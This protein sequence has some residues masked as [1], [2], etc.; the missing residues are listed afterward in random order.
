M[1]NRWRWFRFFLWL[2]VVGF[3]LWV[4]GTLFHM[5][6]IV[7]LW[8]ANPPES[9][10]DFFQGTNFTRTVLNFFGPPWMLARN[11]PLL[12]ALVLGWQFRTH[13]K[14]LLISVCCM[15]FAVIFTLVYVYRINAILMTPAA[16]SVSADVI[17]VL[18]RKWIFADRLRFG[19]GFAGFLSLLK[20]FGTP[21]S[22]E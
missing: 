16:N 18:V 10:V 2:S 15:L 13:R 17:K 19:V 5:V 9:V 8:S 4:G 14:Y 7:P 20:A 21:L 22:N 12:A 6:V 1:G 3:A 11:L